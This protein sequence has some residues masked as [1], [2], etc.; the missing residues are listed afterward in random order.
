MPTVP[1]PRRMRRAPILRRKTQSPW[2]TG[3][4]RWFRSVR[5]HTTATLS[6]RAPR[7]LWHISYQERSS[8]LVTITS[9]ARRTWASAQPFWEALGSTIVPERRDS[10]AGPF[11]YKRLHSPLE[12]GDGGREPAEGES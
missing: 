1:A 2:T 12:H 11:G 6:W 7:V 4:R 9:C 10:W 8:S 3:S 5:K